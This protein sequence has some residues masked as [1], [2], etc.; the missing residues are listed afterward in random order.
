MISTG[1]RAM[2]TTTASSRNQ[3]GVRESPVPRWAII[4]KLKKYMNGIARKI[5][6]R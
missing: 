1:F 6:R 4:R 5:T 2:S 3:K